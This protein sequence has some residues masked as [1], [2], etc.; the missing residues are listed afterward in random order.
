MILD[1]PTT[2]YWAITIAIISIQ[3]RTKN[4]IFK[5]R[6]IVPIANVFW[7]WTVLTWNSICVKLMK[8]KRTCRISCFIKWKL[9]LTIPFYWCCFLF[10][11]SF[12][13]SSISVPVYTCTSSF[14]STLNISYRIKM[15]ATLFS[16]H[17]GPIIWKS[18]SF[19]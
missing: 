13:N 17:R 6:I 2:P 12:F 14:C 19:I 8:K 16:S 3:W 10:R 4:G 1:A 9:M 15:A 7:N 18:S 11:E 5:Y